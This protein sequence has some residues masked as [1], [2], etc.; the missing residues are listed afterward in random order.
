[1]TDIYKPQEIAIKIRNGKKDSLDS[2]IKEMDNISENNSNKRNLVGKITK[3]TIS[4][5][6]GMIVLSGVYLSMIEPYF[7]RIIKNTEETVKYNEVNY[8]KNRLETEG[9]LN[10]V[11]YV[12]NKKV[13]KKE[14]INA[15]PGES[16]EL[17]LDTSI[18]SPLFQGTAGPVEYFYGSFWAN[19]EGSG[20]YHMPLNEPFFVLR[21]D[22][23]KGDPFRDTDESINKRKKL[24]AGKESFKLSAPEEE[25]VYRLCLEYYIDPTGKLKSEKTI[26][27]TKAALGYSEIYPLIVGNSEPKVFITDYEPKYEVNGKKI[28]IIEISNIGSTDAKDFYV[29][30]EYYPSKHIDKL[31][32]GKSMILSYEMPGKSGLTYNTFTCIIKDKKII[33]RARTDN[34]GGTE[35]QSMLWRQYVEEQE[36]KNKSKISSY[37]SDK[38]SG[39]KRY[40]RSF[41]RWPRRI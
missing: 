16:L 21:N 37:V 32:P 40:V 20:Y 4:G 35:V 17:K 1:M 19:I 33:S 3:W 15:N 23:P 28:R 2:A 36:N 27:K 13:G 14:I 10:S 6:S 18:K 26:K 5:I 39:L 34:M 31:Q 8:V 9:R 22:F 24:F 11:L 12:N 30:N 41:N 7:G 25:G 38:I 29:K